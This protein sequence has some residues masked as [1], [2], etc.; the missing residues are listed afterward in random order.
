MVATEV[1][2]NIL[3][4]PTVTGLDTLVIDAIS[5]MADLVLLI[6]LSLLI[7]QRVR[8]LSQEAHPHFRVSFLRPVNMRSTFVLLKQQNLLLLLMLPKLVMSLL[9]L[10]IHLHLGSLIP[11]PLIISLVIKT[12]FLPLPFRLLY[13]LLP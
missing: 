7:I 5:Y 11:E 1:K 4:A 2:G 13:P 3:I 6:W 10:H 12:S 9:A 8:V